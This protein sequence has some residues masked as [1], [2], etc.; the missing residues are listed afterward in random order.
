MCKWTKKEKKESNWTKQTNKKTQ[1]GMDETH[2]K[3]HMDIF[4][5]PSASFSLP[6]PLPPPSRSHPQFSP[7]FGEKLFGK[8]RV[9]S[10]SPFQPNTFKKVLLP[11]F[12]FFIFLSSL[13]STLPNTALGSQSLKVS[14]SHFTS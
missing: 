10:L 7:H 3:V 8:A 1:M 2:V 5:S 14:L 9:F 6:W 4:V 12:L 13:K 11:H